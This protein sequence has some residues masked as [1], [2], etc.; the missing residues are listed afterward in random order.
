MTERMC[1]RPGLEDRRSAPG[2]FLWRLFK[3]DSARC[4]RLVS[5]I[6]VVGEKANVRKRSD[7]ALLAGWREQ[8]QFGF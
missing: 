4:Q 7:P 3:F 5:L 1:C 6:H 8:G 2:L